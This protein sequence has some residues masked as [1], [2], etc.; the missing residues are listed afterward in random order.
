VA[1]AARPAARGRSAE[2]YTAASA[3][4]VPPVVIRQALPAYSAISQMMPVYVGSQRQAIQGAVEVTIAEDGKV[5]NARMRV[6]TKTAYDIVAVAAANRWQYKP[7]S[8]DGAPV[9]YLKVV[10]INVA[11]AP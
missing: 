6:S 4:V 9:K 3:G 11:A 8:L 10:N 2:I 5:I 1:A 7:A